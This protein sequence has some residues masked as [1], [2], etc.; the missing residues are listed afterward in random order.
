[1]LRHLGVHRKLEESVS[2]SLSKGNNYL[3]EWDASKS[4]YDVCISVVAASYLEERMNTSFLPIFTKEYYTSS[5]AEW[6]PVLLG[7]HVR[8]LITPRIG[9]SRTSKASWRWRSSSRFNPLIWMSLT[10]KCVGLSCGLVP[11]IS[12]IGTLDPRWIWLLYL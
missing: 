2:E 1:M 7:S 4:I 6:G 10:A 8:I 12:L 9:G 5:I 11:N 3:G